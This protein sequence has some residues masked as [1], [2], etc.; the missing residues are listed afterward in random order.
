[1][2]ITAPATERIRQLRLIWA[3]MVAAIF[4]YWAVRLLVAPRGEELTWPSPLPLVLLALA[5]ADYALAWWWYERAIGR[6]SR[7]LT[8]TAAQHMPWAERVR[9]ADRV[10]GSV[11]VCFACVETPVIL[12]LI[13]SFGQSTIPQLFEGL[14]VTSLAAL[15]VFRARLFPDVARLLEVLLAGA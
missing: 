13:N 4:F 15:V 2:P 8:P 1:M 12:G 5:A 6:L 7:A 9:L 10:F 11:L 3:A 14:T